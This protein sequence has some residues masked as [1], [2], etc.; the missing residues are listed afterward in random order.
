M[1]FPRR[2]FLSLAASAAALPALPRIA[3]AQGYPTRPVRLVVGFPAGGTNDLHA[4]L[5]ADGS[6]NTSVGPSLS[7][8]GQELPATSG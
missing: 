5:I 1:K 3:R 6:P 2:R 4:R 7:K 8:T